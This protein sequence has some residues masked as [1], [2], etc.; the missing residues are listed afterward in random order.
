MAVPGVRHGGRGGRGDGRRGAGEGEPR[1]QG[2]SGGELEMGLLD[3]ESDEVRARIDDWI[4]GAGGSFTDE[5]GQAA[6][7][8]ITPEEKTKIFSRID[9]ENKMLESQLNAKAS[10]NDKM[11]NFI[12]LANKTGGDAIEGGFGIAA[13]IDQT[14]SQVAQAVADVEKQE[15]QQVYS[16]QTNAEQEATQFL[17]EALQTTQIARQTTA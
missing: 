8:H 2:A 1:G 11:S 12:S 10:S 13:S 15:G 14:Q 4:S 6:L 3:R 17:Q 16:S 5:V 9:Q 7:N